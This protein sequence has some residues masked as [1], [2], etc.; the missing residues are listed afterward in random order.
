VLRFVEVQVGLL[1]VVDIP[2][3]SFVDSTIVEVC[4]ISREDGPAILGWAM[5][6]VDGGRLGRVQVVCLSLTFG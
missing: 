1:E 3:V 5:N 2:L 6:I 4:M